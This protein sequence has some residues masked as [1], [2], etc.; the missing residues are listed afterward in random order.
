MPRKARKMKKNK[1]FL[2]F[3]LHNLKNCS[4]FARFY[5]YGYVRVSVK[6]NEIHATRHMSPKRRVIHQ[7]KNHALVAKQQSKEH[8]GGAIKCN[9]QCNHP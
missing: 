6:S 8:S 9:G 5:E 1:R 2:R 3:F 4:N 7:I